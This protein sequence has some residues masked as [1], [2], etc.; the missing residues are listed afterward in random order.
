MKQILL[1]LCF[2]IPLNTSS[3]S[4]FPERDYDN[5]VSG[6]MEVY[7]QFKT[8]SKEES[9]K[10]YSFVQS[11]WNKTTC[12]VDCSEVGGFVA[13]QYAKERKIEIKSKKDTQK[14]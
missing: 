13:K 14:K 9:E 2:I 8:P 7:S 6:A 12:N 3:H 5:F 11:T 1:A 4:L 10:F